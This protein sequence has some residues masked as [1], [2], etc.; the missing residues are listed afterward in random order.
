MR[1]FFNLASDY[2]TIPDEIGMEAPDLQTA[3]TGALRSI[4][5][6]RDE[7]PASVSDWSGWL[8]EIADEN[9]FVQKTIVLN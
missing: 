3:I 6:L 2:D 9:G 7:I 8:L 4:E 5:E 1:Y